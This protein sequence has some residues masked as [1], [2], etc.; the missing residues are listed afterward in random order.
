MLADLVKHNAPALAAIDMAAW[1]IYARKQNKTV[2]EILLWPE[3]SDIV[4]H[5]Y[6]LGVSLFDDMQRKIDFG[7]NAGFSCFKLKLDGTC[8]ERV[9]ADFKKLSDHPIAVDANQAWK[10]LE[11]AQSMLGILEQAGCMLIEQPFHRSDR[12]WSWRLSDSTDIPIIADEACQG[13]DDMAEV[14]NF[15]DGV[16]V[17]LQKCGGIT[18]AVRML[19]KLTSSGKLALIGCM[20]E[21]AIGCNAAESITGKCNWADLDGPWLNSNNEELLN[22][23]NYRGFN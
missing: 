2:S 22:Q 12:E 9:I 15:F 13:E 6:T 14:L 17:K 19:D 1:E 7:L 4:P 5:T 10:S 16:N 18:P 20:S 21:S 11:Q 8:D 3:P 23:L